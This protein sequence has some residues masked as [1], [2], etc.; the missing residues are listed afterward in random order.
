MHAHISSYAPCLLTCFCMHSWHA[1]IIIECYRYF[2]LWRDTPFFL[3]G[4]AG[5]QLVFGAHEAHGLILD[6][7][8]QSKACMDFGSRWYIVYL[9]ILLPEYVG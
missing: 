3:K 2:L 9:R 5:K 4:V 1:I 6:F 7:G 8:L